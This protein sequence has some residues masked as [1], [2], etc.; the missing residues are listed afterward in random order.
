MISLRTRVALLVSA[1][2]LVISVALGGYLW[3]EV[4]HASVDALDRELAGEAEVLSR[5]L[6]LEGDGSIEFDEHGRGGLE[7]PHRIE[8]ADGKVISQ[9]GLRWPALLPGDVHEE[10]SEFLRDGGPWRVLTRPIVLQRRGN[11]ARLVLRVAVSAAPTLE[12]RQRVERAVVVAVIGAGLL[13]A[14]AA[15]LVARATTGPLR[16]LAARVG[17]LEPA[18]IGSELPREGRDREVVALTDAFNDLLKRLAAA[19]ARQR[20]LVARASH[21]LRTPTATILT[22]AEVTLARNRSEPEYRA[23]IEEIAEAARESAALVQHLLSLARLDERSTE[24]RTEPVELFSLAAELSRLLAPRAAAAGV[25]LEFD[26]PPGATLVADKAA[27]R[28]LLEALLDNALR[29]TP[30]G[31]SAGLL[32]GERSITVWDTGPGMSDEEKGRAFERFFRGRAAELSGAPGSGLGLAIARAIAERHGATIELAD[33][34]GGGLE[35]I[36]RWHG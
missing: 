29:Y 23:A 11:S 33:R 13:G 17:S 28:E 20:Q 10:H 35:V 5:L 9:T 22:R 30:R 31:G 24:L 19:F 7:I 4:R 15:M 1:L 8:T 32:A 14:I 27:L 36:V 6:H 12:L 18:S 34:P 26:V 2:S 21:A 16:R 3:H 25:Q